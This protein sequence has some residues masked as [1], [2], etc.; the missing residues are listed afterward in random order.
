L[1]VSEILSVICI[2]SSSSVIVLLVSFDR[3]VSMNPVL[4]VPLCSSPLSR[5]KESNMLRN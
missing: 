4:S 5:S 3:T 2:S 1:V